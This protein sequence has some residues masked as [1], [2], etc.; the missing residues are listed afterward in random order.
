MT[1]LQDL[2]SNNLPQNFLLINYRIFFHKGKKKL[3]KSTFYIAEPTHEGQ[4]A[5]NDFITVS[6]MTLLSNLHN[7][8]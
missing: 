7:L 6:A 4:H 5:N 1:F 2:Q 3:D 8:S